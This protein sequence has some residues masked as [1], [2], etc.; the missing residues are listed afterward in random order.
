T[1]ALTVDTFRTVLDMMSEYEDF[2]FAQ[3]QASTYEIVEKYRPDMLDE[4]K[5]RIKEGRW[6]VT[7]AEWVEPDKNM[8]SGE[9]LVRQLLEAKKYLEELLELDDGQI[10]IDFVPDTFGH[11][12]T[13]P[14]I[15][16][17]AGIPYMY[18][19]RGLEGPCFYRYRAPSGKELL[20]YRE[21]RWYNSAISPLSFEV[22]PVFCKQ[23]GLDTYLC[24]YG[25]GD[26][27]GGPSRRDIERIIEYSKWPLTPDIGFGTFKEFF[28]LAMKKYDKW[29]I[30]DRELNFLFSGCY[31]TQAR[32]KMSNR[33]SEARIFEAESLAATATAM[34]N[35]PSMA[36][37]YE[38]PWRNILFNHFHDI[39]PGSGKPETREHA[40]GKFQDTLADVQT[41]ASISMN[42]I[43][44]A[45][46]TSSI[47]FD[48]SAKSEHRSEGAGV[49]YGVSE[50]FNF[51]MPSTERGRGA[52]RAFHVFNPTQ[53]DRCEITE[54]A[55]WDYYHDIS[56]VGFFDV[57]GDEL[58]ASCV[59]P[60]RK[61]SEKDGYWGYKYDK[62]MVKVSVPAMGYT[63][64]VMR[65]K[66]QIGHFAPPI[67]SAEHIDHLDVNNEPI[68]LE[69]SLIKAT[70]SKTE[71]KLL[72]LYDKTCGKYLIDKPS[73]F[74]KYI[75]EDPIYEYIAWRIGPYMKVV[76][77]NNSC[78]TMFTEQEFKKTFQSFSYVFDFQKTSFKVKV[79]LKK[80]S[81]VL[82]FD[83][84]VDFN[85]DPVVGKMIPQIAFSVPVSYEVKGSRCRIPFGVLERPCA[86]FDV[87]SHGCVGIMG[88][89]DREV[90]IIAP[91]K[92]G[93]RC[94]NGEGQVTLL[95]NAYKPDPYSD[96]GEH[97]IRIC[98]GVSSPKE[99]ERLSDAMEHP[100]PYVSA[101]YHKGSLPLEA[102]LV[103]IDG[104]VRVSA[105]KNAEDS[106]G[107]VLRLYET[108]GQDQSV[109]VKA[110]CDVKEAYVTDVHERVVEKLPIEGG[111]VSLTVSKNAITTL[112]LVL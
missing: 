64:V 104:D 23:E 37:R 77:L 2:T 108:K 83:L 85:N 102:S 103:K 42:A 65:P 95:R 18:H 54:I 27:G 26:H 74:F 1:A 35:A 44:A 79:T 20:A 8:P 4:I 50:R 14:E 72:S 38:N 15:L 76:D 9:S 25:V 107:I 63:T 92:Y 86:S 57:N 32:I 7:A 39:L 75:E 19:C 43:A 12:S 56:R 106:S 110:R 80:D 96:R 17:N 99:L 67:I 101:K 30:I 24:V 33:I 34:T 70:F 66:P 46:D 105:L 68:V 60:A 78:A 40:M 93:Y 47:D 31:T 73:C 21:F 55:V 51:V 97:H 94:E 45:T 111:T 53:Y 22:T 89:C 16:C 5:K 109:T 82:D 36:K 91:T 59:N 48:T 49:G 71:G 3:S 13:I 6:E 61:G 81:P 62:F 69:N 52:V 10:C 11:A 28:D 41:G 98:V 58:E 112:K 29:P 84:T 88:D 87:P 90:V 100:L